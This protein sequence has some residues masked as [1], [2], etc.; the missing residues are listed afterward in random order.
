M[1]GKYGKQIIGLTM[2]QIAVQKLLE[3]CSK[4]GA[5][6]GTDTH[7]AVAGGTLGAKD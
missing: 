3:S 7:H 1:T 4:H 5:N 2:R 6:A